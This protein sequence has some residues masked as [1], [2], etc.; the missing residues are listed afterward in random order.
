MVANL[1]TR[2]RKAS[3]NTSAGC[4]CPANAPSQRRH[5][6]ADAS[7]KS[8]ND[9]C[10]QAIA[11]AASRLGCLAGSVGRSEDRRAQAERPESRPGCSRERLPQ[12]RARQACAQ[13]QRVPAHN[14][15]SQGVKPHLADEERGPRHAERSVD[16]V[17]NA[18]WCR[19]PDAALHCCTRSVNARLRRSINACHSRCNE[20]I[21]NSVANTRGRNHKRKNREHGGD[22]NGIQPEAG[23]HQVWILRQRFSCDRQKA[24]AQDQ[25]G[26]PQVKAV[27][28]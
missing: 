19:L 22:V 12:R 18:R 26:A 10:K 16:D 7:H 6:F 21:R 4:F 9:A 25:L 28:G 15:V 1:R 2:G 14:D 11:P 3:Q 5:E 27:C 8:G 23:R 13:R 20:R 24:A 17:G